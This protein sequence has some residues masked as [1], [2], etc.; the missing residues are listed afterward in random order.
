L[1]GVVTFLGAALGGV[2]TFLGCQLDELAPD[3]A[4]GGSRCTM[5]RALRANATK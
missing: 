2:V 3:M 4:E 5:L 1:G